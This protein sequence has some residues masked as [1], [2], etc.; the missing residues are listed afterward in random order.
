MEDWRKR[1]GEGGGWSEGIRW[2]L[3]IEKKHILSHDMTVGSIGKEKDEEDEYVFGC[4]SVKNIIY[5][6]WIGL[7]ISW[8][9][10]LLQREVNLLSSLQL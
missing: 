2:K 5:K 7:M 8:K 1:R 3:N 4:E 10:T 9:Y 6:I